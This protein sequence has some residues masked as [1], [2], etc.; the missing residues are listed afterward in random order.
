MRK[1]GTHFFA[2]FS[3]VG[4][5]VAIGIGL[6]LIDGVWMTMGSQPHCGPALASNGFS[7]QQRRHSGRSEGSSQEPR[8]DA[9]SP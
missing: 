6:S 4:S 8:T 5:G 2:S 7:G 9:G 1:I 3:H